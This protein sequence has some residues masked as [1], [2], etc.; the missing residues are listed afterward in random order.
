MISE[1]TTYNNLSQSFSPKLNLASR[2]GVLLTVVGLFLLLLAVFNLSLIH[3]TQLLPITITLITVGVLL[4]SYNVYSDVNYKRYRYTFTQPIATRSTLSWILAIFVTSFYVVLYFFPKYLG[5][6]PNN[7][8]NTGLIVVF[9]PLSYILNGHKASEWFVY[10]TLYTIAVLL[11][12]IRFIIKYKGNRYQQLRTLSIL[13]FQC[14]FAF[15]LPELMQQLNGHPNLPYTDVKHL[16]PL[17][18]YQFEQYRVDAYI[19]SGSL[20]IGLLIFSI[21]SI[22]IVS[23]ILTYFYGKR[24][25]CSWVCG[26]GGLAETAGD[27]FRHLGS[28]KLRS[29]KIERWMIHTILVICIVTTLA[30]ISSYL[31]ISSSNYWINRAQFLLISA[32]LLAIAA[33]LL[34]VLW[35]KKLPQDAVRGGWISAGV[36]MLFIVWGL[37]Y[38]EGSNLLISTTKLRSF[39]GFFIGALFSGVI[40]AGFYPILGGRFWCRYGCPMAAILGIQ[41]KLFSKFRITTNHNQCISCGNCSVYCEMGIDVRSYAQKGENIN[42]A[43]CVGCGICAD[44]CPR[45][46]LKLENIPR[47][48]TNKT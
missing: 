43:S 20:G 26:C 39:Y 28:Y 38:P 41:Q 36:I 7:Q 44:V 22:F 19:N 16:W 5:L 47:I 45:G 37:L 40:G 14:G 35:R 30:V 8:I 27:S 17:N 13:F 2:L 12:G 31:E 10:G 6:T 15:L 18:Y 11:F 24:W 29:W 34:L 23:P 33:L 4:Y 9:D 32:A 46:V 21:V 25:Y 1:N 48:T 3:S 42:R